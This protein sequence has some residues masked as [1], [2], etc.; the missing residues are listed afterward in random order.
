L[1]LLK[2]S[3]FTMFWTKLV[4]PFSKR[5]FPCL[6]PFSTMKSD[7]GLPF[8]ETYIVMV[9]HACIHPIHVFGKL[10]FW[11]INSKYSNWLNRA[12]FPSLSQSITSLTTTTPSINRVY[13]REILYAYL[14]LLPLVPILAYLVEFLPTP[15]IYKLNWSILWENM[16]MIHFWILITTHI[17]RCIY[18]LFTIRTTVYNI[19]LIDLGHSDKMS[20]TTIQTLSKEPNNTFKKDRELQCH[21]P[22]Y[23]KK[24]TF[25]IS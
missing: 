16:W 17:T 8:T 21:L 7:V 13:L 24:W 10:I 9:I 19:D 4:N 12:H 18:L 1:K 2:F 23:S 5:K 14:I 6:N 15:Y 11:N 25:N 22:Y 3:I 20:N